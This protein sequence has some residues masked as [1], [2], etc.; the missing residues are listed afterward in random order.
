[1]ASNRAE[2][3]AGSFV[4]GFQGSDG[5]VKAGYS[6]CAADK[7]HGGQGSQHHEHL[8]RAAL[9]RAVPRDSAVQ[10][11]VVALMGQ[12]WPL[13]RFLLAF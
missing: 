2:S 8:P 5:E 1:M 13:T 4:S 3:D 7:G 10:W 12:V 11:R 6:D 9:G